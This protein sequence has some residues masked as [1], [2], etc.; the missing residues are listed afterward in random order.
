MTKALLEFETITSFP[1]GSPIGLPEGLDELAAFVES[2]RSAYITISYLEPG[3]M[4]LDWLKER[5]DIYSQR[6]HSLQETAA[7]K[8]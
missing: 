1:V 7:L 3:D 4:A 5:L 6:L 8:D 2:L